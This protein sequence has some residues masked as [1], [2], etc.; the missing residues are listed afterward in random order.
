MA[1]TP[2]ITL[3][4]TLEDFTGADV[5]NGSIFVTLCG[6]GQILPRVLGTAMI[7]RVSQK[8]MLATGAS[9]GIALYGNDQITPTGTFYSISVMDDKKNIV[10]SGI[11]I[12]E[13]GTQTIDLS[14]ATQITIQPTPNSGGFFEEEP[15]GLFPG[16]TYQLS[17]TP[18][19]SLPVQLWYNGNKLRNQVNSVVFDFSVIGR[20]ITLNFMTVE[21]DNLDA[22]YAPQ[23][24]SFAFLIEE[25][26]DGIF[27]GNTYTLRNAPLNALAPVQLF[28]NGNKLRNQAFFSPFDFSIVGKVISLNFQTQAG[29]NLDAL[30]IPVSV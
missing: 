18:S 23:Q 17:F 15:E 5:T 4:V 20:T 12:F 7:A 30:Y 29:D 8:F 11:Y 1:S 28:L 16:N 21:G 10:Q 13:G 2:E 25:Q 19:S 27:P 24:S 9:T 3:T 14:N 26:P 6:F 22:F